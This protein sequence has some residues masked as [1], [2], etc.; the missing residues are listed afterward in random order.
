MD[1]NS[2]SRYTSLLKE[3]WV[4]LGYLHE[5]DSGLT[6][7]FHPLFQRTNAL[8]PLGAEHIWP[9]YKSEVEYHAMCAE[10]GTIFQMASSMLETSKSLDFLYQV[11]NSPRKVSNTGSSNQ[12]RPCKEFG[13]TEPPSKAMARQAA[14][15]ALRRLSR[16]LTFQIGD[17]EANPAV[18]GSFGS[19]EVT[20][21]H[22]LEG[23]KM[24]D[25][26]SKSGMASK[27][28][29]NEDY[30]LRLR[31]LDNQEGDTTSQRISLQLKMAI[32]LCHEIAHALAF[33][34]DEEILEAF[35]GE[36]DAFVKAS[37]EGREYQRRVI[38]TDEPFYRNETMAEIGY[39]WE[40]QVFGGNVFWSSK[41]SDPLFVSK[42]PSLFTDSEFPKRGKEKRTARRYVV[43]LH[44]TRNMHRQ[45]FWDNL[46]PGDS[47]ALYIKKTIGIE[48]I[49]PD[50][51][52]LSID[53]SQINWPRDESSSRVS[54]E[55][56]GQP[57]PDPS[58]SRANETEEERRAR[59]LASEPRI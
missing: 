19:T 52:A 54:R 33:A 59:E 42:W 29:L 50:E 24:N 15:D 49:N 53:S 55:R 28:T 32:T 57:I 47:T 25:V 8:R 1:S 44:F 21:D 43:S 56:D 16:F 40:N 20:L 27:I 26:S 18:R 30:I 5:E 39:C 14:R 58:A 13:W 34:V 2:R 10:M 38:G 3:D 6:R 4:K 17:P 31:E 45:G 12:G 37:L 7:K 23:V 11:A 22:F 35:T 36:Y 9:Q 48:Y 41:T 46:V 51:E